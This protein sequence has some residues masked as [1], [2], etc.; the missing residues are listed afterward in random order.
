MMGQAALLDNLGRAVLADVLGGDNDFGVLGV[1]D[2]VHGAAHALEELARDHEV[3]EVA[4]LADLQGA[5]DGHVDVAAADHAKGLG[6]VKGGGAGDEGDGLL[7]G[8]DKVTI[9][10]TFT[11]ANS[12]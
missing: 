3:G 5:E 9:S 6:R 10:K 12:V 7:A 8:V 4:G 1:G 11:L 2:E